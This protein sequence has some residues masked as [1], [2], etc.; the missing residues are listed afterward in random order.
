[1]VGRFMKHHPACM[2][3]RLHVYLEDAEWERLEAWSRE[4]GW[5]KSQ[6]IRAALGTVMRIDGDPLL[7]LSGIVAGLRPDASEKLDTYLEEG[8]VAARPHPNKRA[9]APR[10]RR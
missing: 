1:M 3:R 7:G 5:T 9:P 2:S 6:A 4:R 8:F 10:V